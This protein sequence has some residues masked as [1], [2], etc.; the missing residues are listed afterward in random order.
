MDARWLR[1]AAAAGAGEEAPGGLGCSEHHPAVHEEAL[2]GDQ[3]RCCRQAAARPHEA[4][5]VRRPRADLRTC[6]RS[7]R[8]LSAALLAFRRV[9]WVYLPPASTSERHPS[10]SNSSGA[11]CS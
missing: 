7:E 5:R 9:A 11:A 1:P 2:G 4:V 3:R 6:V 10:R 8:E